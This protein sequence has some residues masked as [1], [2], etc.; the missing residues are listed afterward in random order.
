[1]NHF[2]VTNPPIAKTLFESTKSA[3]FWLLVRLYV[4][5]AWLSAGMGKVGSSSW[6][7][8]DAGASVKGFVSGALEKTVGAHPDVSA[9]YAYFLE[10]VVLP[11]TEVFGYIIA[12]GEVLVGVALILGVLV[13]IASFFG[14]FMNL[15]FLLSGTVSSNPEL[16]VLGVGL[17]L[18]WKVAGHWGIDRWL[19]PAL[20]TPWDRKQEK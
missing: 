15:N 3:W 12:Y 4:G 18:A 16:F 14:I 5:W 20:G 17:M 11:N 1:M 19:L 8:E 7:G 13:G 10:K 9:W 2:H 6:T